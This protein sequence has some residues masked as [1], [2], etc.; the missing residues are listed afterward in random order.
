MS[1]QT[2]RTKELEETAFDLVYRSSILRDEGKKLSGKATHLREA[3]KKI[4]DE[5]GRNAWKRNQPKSV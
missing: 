2:E 5:V 3:S 1:D 4:R